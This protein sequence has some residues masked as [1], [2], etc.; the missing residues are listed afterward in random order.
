[1]HT[2][3]SRN[4]QVATDTRLFLKTQWILTLLICGL[5]KRVLLKQAERA[6]GTILPGMTHLQHAQPVSLA[7]H[8]LAYFWMFQRDCERL[9]QQSAAHYVFAFRFGGFG[10]NGFSD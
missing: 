8:L 6:A 2:A 5:C 4:D 1:M 7:H 3:R 9:T 10:W